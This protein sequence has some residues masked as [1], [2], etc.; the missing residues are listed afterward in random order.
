M[1]TQATPLKRMEIDPQ[2]QHREIE[3]NQGALQVSVLHMAQVRRQ[4]DQRLL[5]AHRLLTLYLGRAK[6]SIL[7]SIQ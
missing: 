2:R 4:S 3:H 7:P 1:E 6:R 5:M